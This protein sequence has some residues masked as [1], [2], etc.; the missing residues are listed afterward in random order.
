MK[1]VRELLIRGGFDRR[2]LQTKRI[3]VFVP[4]LLRS[5]EGLV[6]LLLHFND[7]VLR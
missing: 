4:G 6:V 3:V 7:P 2:I 5:V 1:L